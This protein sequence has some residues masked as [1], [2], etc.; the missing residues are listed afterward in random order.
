MLMGLYSSALAIIQV[1]IA[2]N[3]DS[4][5]SIILYTVLVTV[6]L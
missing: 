3:A 5:D 2:Y 1:V 4:L 6:K